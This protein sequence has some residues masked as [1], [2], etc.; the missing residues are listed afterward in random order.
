MHVLPIFKSE[1]KVQSLGDSLALTL[2]SLYTKLNRI[3]KGEK[4]NTYFL[5]EDVLIISNLD[6]PGLMKG[7]TEFLGKLE[8]KDVFTE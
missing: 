4:L 6:E 8:K 1:R 5:T 2:P 7:I 3:D